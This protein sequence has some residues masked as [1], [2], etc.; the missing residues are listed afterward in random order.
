M[1]ASHEH[2]ETIDD[3][4]GIEHTVFHSHG[5]AADRDFCVYSLR[6]ETDTEAL[7][8]ERSIQDSRVPT[9]SGCVRAD[10]HF[11]GALI[12]KV[13]EK[14]TRV[15]YARRVDMGG[16]IPGFLANLISSK[17]PLVLAQLRDYAVTHQ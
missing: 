13:S 14:Q 4:S 17:Q 10:S 9:P 6:L 12:Q 5:G 3:H 2:I 8:F 15:I 16:R 7:V 11:T 1:F